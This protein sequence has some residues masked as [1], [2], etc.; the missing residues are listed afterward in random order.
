MLLA[1]S[2]AFSKSFGLAITFIGLGIVVTIVIVYMIIQLRGEHVQ[3]REYVA[4]L[5]RDTSPEP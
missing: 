4:S 5:S 1:T 2:T 3:N